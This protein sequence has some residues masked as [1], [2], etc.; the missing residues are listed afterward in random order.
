MCESKCFDTLK[1]TRSLKP[2]YRLFMSI[3]IFI[4][5]L[6]LYVNSTAI[7]STVIT[8]MDQQIFDPDAGKNYNAAISAGDLHFEMEKI[9]IHRS[10]PNRS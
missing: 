3:D 9:N 5:L 6:E 4:T 2:T 10:R 8:Q 7:T 1:S